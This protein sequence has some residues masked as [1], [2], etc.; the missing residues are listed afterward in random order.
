VSNNRFDG[1]A[2]AGKLA[3]LFGH[4]PLHTGSRVRIAWLALPK[5]CINASCTAALKAS[6]FLA[7]GQFEAPK[8]RENSQKTAPKTPKTD[9]SYTPK[10]HKTTI[11]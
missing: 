4:L 6:A 2:P 11:K 5:G 7:C 9:R 3:F 1:L 8:K 10:N